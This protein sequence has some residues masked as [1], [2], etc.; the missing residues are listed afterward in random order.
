MELVNR[1][2]LITGGTSGIGLQLVSMLSK[3]NEIIVLARDEHKLTQLKQQFND[4]TVFKCDLRNIDQT[5]EVAEH[6]ACKYQYLDMLVNNAAVQYC[7]KFTDADF[8]QQ[9]IIDEINTN[10]TS[11]CTLTLQLLPTLL[12]QE[13][14]IIL[15]INSGLALTP[16][17]TSAVYC[18]TK[19]ALNNFTQSLRYQLENTNIHVQQV[20][21]PLVDTQMTKA[22]GHN[23][24]SSE[25]AAKQ[26]I[27]GI[28]KNK[29]DH[30][31]SKVSLLMCLLR[32]A[33][34]LAKNIMK[35]Y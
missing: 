15:N 5:R 20:F 32:L 11:V 9:L 21:L 29:V 12:H 33:P 22:R 30:A 24:I 28:K 35:K 3:Q 1:R 13:K 17:T 31:F 19:A 27:V 26:I 25:N 6:I 2:I 4:I 18:A 34:S 7:K 14:S 16:K 10:F 8:H 23:K